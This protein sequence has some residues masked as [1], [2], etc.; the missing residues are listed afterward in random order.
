MSRS[1]PCPDPR[2]GAFCHARVHATVRV[3]ES[4]ETVS[5]DRLY[6]FLAMGRL[7]PKDGLI[8]MKDLQVY[9]VCCRAHRIVPLALASF[10]GL[11]LLL[12]MLLLVLMLVV[13]V[14]A[15]CCWCCWL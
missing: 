13:V 15:V 5:V 7:R 8:S 2:V 14:G 12:L 10:R 6:M 11:F 9:V 1:L 3:D 4:F